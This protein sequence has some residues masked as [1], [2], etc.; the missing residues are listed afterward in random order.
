[1]Q[2]ALTNSYNTAFAKLGVDLGS[3][4]SG[5]GGRRSASAPAT[6]LQTPLRVSPSS[7]G[8]IPDTPR[9]PS[10]RSGSGTWR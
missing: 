4:R 3:R 1:M 6:P 9:W 5:G 2:T 7:L 8:D 10:P